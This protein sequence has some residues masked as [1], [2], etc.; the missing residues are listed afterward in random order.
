MMKS[1][2]TLPNGWVWFEE[3]GKVFIP[4][5]ARLIHRSPLKEDESLFISSKSNWFLKRS[6]NGQEALW[7][8]ISNNEAFLWLVRNQYDF[9][10]RKE[11]SVQDLLDRFEV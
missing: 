6:R 10:R 8:N 9:D 11:D 2:S 3:P 7:E 1:K 5:K 4:Y